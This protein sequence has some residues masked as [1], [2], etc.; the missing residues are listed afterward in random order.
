MALSLRGFALVIVAVAA[1]TVLLGWTNA[2][3][4][5]GHLGGI[6]MGAILIRFFCRGRNGWED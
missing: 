4:E 1:A 6:L 3:G 5:A 2:G